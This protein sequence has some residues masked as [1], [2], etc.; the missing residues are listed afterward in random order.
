MKDVMQKNITANVEATF[1]MK[2]YRKSFLVKNFT[3]KEIWVYLG[4]NKTYSIIGSGSWERVFNNTDTAEDPA[5]VNVVRILGKAEG[6]VEV[7]S[8]E[9]D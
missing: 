1:T 8:L 6:I 3:D 2:L 9:E 5:R 7:A 4:K